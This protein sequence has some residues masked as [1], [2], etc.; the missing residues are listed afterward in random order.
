MSKGQHPH[1]IKL[2]FAPSGLL[3]RF[4]QALGKRK[5]QQAIIVNAFVAA[6]PRVNPRW[7]TAARRKFAP[8]N[9]IFG[10]RCEGLARV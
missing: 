4:S 10:N 3:G 9:A 2:R 5:F 7:L 6:P 1:L 8:A